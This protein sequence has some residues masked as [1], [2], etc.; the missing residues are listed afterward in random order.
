MESA[1]DLN[2]EQCFPC[3]TILSHFG[4][5]LPRGHIRM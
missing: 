3:L 1:L 2:G 4:Y 5:E